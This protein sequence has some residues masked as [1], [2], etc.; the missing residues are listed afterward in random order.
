M[1]T[2]P[3]DIICFG[4][5]WY[6]PSKVSIRH[7]VEVQHE[8]GSRVLWVNPVPI[9]FPATRNR[10]FWTKVQHKAR[11]H[12]RLLSRQGEGLWVYSPVY[13]PLYRGPGFALNRL[14]ISM[15]IILLRLVLGMRK[16]LVFGSMFTAWFA[17]PAV[18]DCPLIFHF[19]DKIS[20][21]REVSGIPERRRVLEEM[22]RSIIKAAVLATCS[23]RAIHEHVASVAGS[24]AEKVILLPH[25]VRA[26]TFLDQPIDAQAI[27][28]EMAALPHPIAGYFGSLTHTNDT[29]TFLAAAQGLPDWSFV[30]IGRVTGDYTALQALPNVHFLGPQ[31]HERI[32]AYGAAF[33][34]CFMGWR[35]HEWI[36]NS[37]PL[38]TLEYLAL[39]KPVVCAGA[40]PEVQERFP[41]LVVT[42]KSPGDFQAALMRE[43]HEDSAA[44]RKARVDAVYQETWERR[45][46]VVLAELRRRG[47]HDG[48]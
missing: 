35:A 26:A 20:A 16:P 21:F 24:G 43:V 13:L 31:P 25:A 28:P 42:T 18:R 33:D 41:G 11:T 38:K 2:Q 5:D 22:E 12:A 34:L 7:L 44:K 8:R 39:G 23:S 1:P 40:I 48:I 46:D 29:E 30:F 6:S 32:P 17:L 19:A 27:P 14:A 10:Q 15:Q 3:R 4:T 9:R 37:F 45:V 47:V 36:T